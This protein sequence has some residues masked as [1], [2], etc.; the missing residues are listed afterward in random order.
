MRLNDLVERND[1]VDNG[2][3]LAF[4]EAAATGRGDLPRPDMIS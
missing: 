2:F 3:K 1:G 4:I